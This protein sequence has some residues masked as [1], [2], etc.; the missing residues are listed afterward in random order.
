MLLGAVA[1]DSARRRL[2]IAWGAGVGCCL[3][4][5]KIVAQCMEELQSGKVLKTFEYCLAVCNY[6]NNPKQLCRGFRFNALL[7]VGQGAFNRQRTLTTVACFFYF[8]I[9]AYRCCLFASLQLGEVKTR[10]SN[11]TLLHVLARIIQEND[12]DLLLL[13]NEVES[14]TVAPAGRNGAREERR[15]GERRRDSLG[16]FLIFD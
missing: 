8:S 2:M 16:L 5:M 12:P 13:V 6:I 3:Q 14:L 9:F 11:V 7:K 15:G 10:E 4:N 1:V